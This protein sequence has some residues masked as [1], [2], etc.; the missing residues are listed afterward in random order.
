MSYEDVTNPISEKFGD[1]VIL[2]DRTSEEWV[3]G[4]IRGRSLKSVKARLTKLKASIASHLPMDVVIVNYHGARA[5]RITSFN[6]KNHTLRFV[7]EETDEVETLHSYDSGLSIY[8][9]NEKY[10]A[11]VDEMLTNDRAIKSLAEDNV[12]LKKKFD[13]KDAITAKALIE[14]YD[15]PVPEDKNAPK[16]KKK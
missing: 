9:Y 13:S 12:N 8:P 5:G 1:A 15:E 2:Y 14:K 16:G 7:D 11:V 3:C 4:E 10:L 6:E